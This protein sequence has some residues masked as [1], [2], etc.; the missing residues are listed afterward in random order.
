MKK[1]GVVC[2]LT[3]ALAACNSA[4]VQPTGANIAKLRV[5]VPEVI[6]PSRSQSSTHSAMKVGVYV[7]DNASCAGANKVISLS[8]RDYAGKWL[9]FGGMD[10]NQVDL[11]MPR[12]KDFDYAPGSFVE[13]GLEPEQKVYVAF[14]AGYS[15]VVCYNTVAFTPSANGNYEAVYVSKNEGCSVRMAQLKGPDPAAAEAVPLFLDKTQACQHF[16]N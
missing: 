16:W 2:L 11:G 8:A 15:G 10:D 14:A 6:D 5:Y 9:E 12:R 3:F 13:F 7:A 4:Y 1:V